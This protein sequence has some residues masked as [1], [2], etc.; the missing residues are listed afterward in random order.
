MTNFRPI[1]LLTVPSNILEKV[2]Y[3]RLNHSMNTNNIIVPE[4]FCF[5]QGKSKDNAAFKLR[6]YS[7][8]LAKKMHV[9]EIF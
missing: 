3:I 2:T 5:S 9:G 4:Q 6:V 7:N 1:S 8:V